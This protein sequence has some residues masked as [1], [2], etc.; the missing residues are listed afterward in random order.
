M[1]YGDSYLYRAGR[2]ILT[3]GTLLSVTMSTTNS[4]ES[5]ENKEELGCHNIIHEAYLLTAFVLH[6]PLVILSNALH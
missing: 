6:S 1:C 2:I 3:V 5:K 4:L